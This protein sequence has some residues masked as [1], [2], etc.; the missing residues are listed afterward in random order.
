ME[1]PIARSTDPDMGNGEAFQSTDASQ[2]PQADL[3]LGLANMNGAAPNELP[4]GAA[5][6][7]EGFKPSA[8]MSQRQIVKPAAPVAPVQAVSYSRGSGTP[9][10]INNAGNLP[11]A[12]FFISMGLDSGKTVQV[13]AYDPWMKPNNSGAAIQNFY[14]IGF[15]NMPYYGYFDKAAAGPWTKGTDYY[16]E[17]YSS[18]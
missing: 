9:P 3:D 2:L 11:G 8:K 18:T 6:E 12:F 13:V 1:D 4:E 10:A 7:I 5:A 15:Q 17:Y 16:G 14:K